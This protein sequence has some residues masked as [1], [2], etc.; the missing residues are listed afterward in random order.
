MPV[1]GK[2]LAYVP[3]SCHAGLAT[4]QQATQDAGLLQAMLAYGDKF[5]WNMCVKLGGAAWNPD[6][7]ICAATYAELFINS[8]VKNSTWIEATVAH[9]DAEIAA[10]G[11]VK[12]WNW[13]D[14]LFMAMSGM[15]G[16][17]SV[18]AVAL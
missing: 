16:L 6:N 2:Q 17:G 7:Q 5:N 8:P 1:H 12:N 10:A 15:Q 9:L 4:L 3:L 18:L 11:S 13:V 14:S